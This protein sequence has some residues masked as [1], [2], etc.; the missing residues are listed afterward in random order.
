MAARKEKSDQLV[1]IFRDNSNRFN[2]SKCIEICEEFEVIE[3]LEYL[4][5]RMGSIKDSMRMAALRIDRILSDRNL[6]D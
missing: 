5:E 2:I 4:Y 1:D 3:G 6:C